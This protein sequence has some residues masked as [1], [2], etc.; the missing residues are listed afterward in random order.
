MNTF[1]LSTSPVLS[2]QQVLP[3]TYLLWV[4][5]PALSKALPGQFAMLRCGETVERV[6]RRPLT[7][8]AVVGENVAFLFRV[9][10]EGT[11]WLSGLVEGAGIDILGPL[12]NS[13]TLNGSSNRLLLVAG[14]LGVA[15]L[16]LLAKRAVEQGKEVTVMLG[17]RSAPLLCPRDLLPEQAS[18]IL[19]TEDGSKDE[20][21]LITDV[22][23]RYAAMA[24]CIYA[25]GP[26]GMYRALAHLK[27][28]LPN[29][30]KVEVSLEVR[31]GCGVGVCLSCTVK[32][33]NGLKHVCK[34]GPVFD[35]DDLDW[36][37]LGQRLL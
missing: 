22:L 2:N 12:G 15:P 24:D 29:G 7:V 34:D 20:K 36:G 19:V 32:T 31:M 6:L 4:H 13:F 35:L 3:D 11:R 17:A 21:G 28:R 25:C 18:V 23:P 16:G 1:S 9:V 14:G 26:E 8:H 10:G 5:A 30:L 33:R 37:D 27:P